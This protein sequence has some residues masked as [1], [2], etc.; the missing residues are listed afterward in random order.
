MTEN[1]KLCTFI[2]KEYKAL[3]ISDAKF[4]KLAT[5][6]LGFTVKLYQ[7]NSRRKAL[8]ISTRGA[9]KPKATLSVENRIQRL[10]KEF[11]SLLPILVQIQNS[12]KEKHDNNGTV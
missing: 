2:K 11:E 6:K 4:S 1:Y 10:E 3:N 9:I 8:G 12:L 5:E 7:V